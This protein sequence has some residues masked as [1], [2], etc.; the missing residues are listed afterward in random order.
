MEGIVNFHHDLFFFLVVVIGFVAY[1]L[2][3]AITLF[4]T[5]TN[6][7]PLVVTHAPMLEII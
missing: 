4:N 7:T 2:Y 6:K 5:E 1:M 3:R